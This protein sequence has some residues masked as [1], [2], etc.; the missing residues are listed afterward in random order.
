MG[1][2]SAMLLNALK[3]M[4]GVPDEV[5]LIAPTIIEPIQ[6]LKT[7]QLGGHNPH[8]H[9]GE[10]LIALT[11]CAATDDQ[12]KAALEQVD[13]L[14]GAEVHSTVILSPV[15]ESTFHKL[16]VNLTSEP[17]YQTKKLFHG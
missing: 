13:K 6:N 3:V 9:V 17:Q 15:D 12:A 10:I 14:R 2:T 7:Q 1:A 8:L 4:A 16:G 5:D 11:I